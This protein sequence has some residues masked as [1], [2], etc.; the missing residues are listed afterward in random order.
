[1]LVRGTF[2]PVMLYRAEPCE[3]APFAKDRNLS[4]DRRSTF[5]K[6]GLAI[7]FALRCTGR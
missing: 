3:G 6:T 7:F 5:D 4:I 2:A 1:M